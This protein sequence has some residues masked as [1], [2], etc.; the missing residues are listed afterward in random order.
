MRLGANRR[1]ATA[2]LVA[3]SGAALLATAGLAA[4]ALNVQSNSFD[5]AGSETRQ[6]VATCGQTAVSGGFYAPLTEQGPA[7]AALDSTREGSRGWRLR[8]RNP[9]GDGTATAYVYCDQPTPALTTRSAQFTVPGGSARGASAQCGL[10]EEAVSGGFDAPDA[11]S[12]LMT[13][14]RTDI[15]TWRVAFV[16]PGRRSSSVHRLRLLRPA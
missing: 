5:V 15:R 2:V 13:S 1:R 7:M 3:A 11:N 14:R 8:V 10:G 6:R 12:Y 4:A 16:Q 9:G